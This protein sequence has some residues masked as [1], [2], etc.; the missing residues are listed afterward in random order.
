APL[1][2]PVPVSP[3]QVGYVLFTSGSTGEPKGVEAAARTAA[4]PPASGAGDRRLQCVLTVANAEVAAGWYV[5]MLGCRVLAT[6]PEFGWVELASPV[7]GVS[8]GLSEIPTAG[9]SGGAVLDFQV[10]DLE[11]VRELLDGDGT[12]PP[13]RA[14]DVAGVARFLEASDIDGNRLMFYQPDDERKRI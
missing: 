8:I 4:R 2:A 3:D 12:T 14:R 1:D 6:I 11:R 10:D 7:P 13:A 9:V 5:R